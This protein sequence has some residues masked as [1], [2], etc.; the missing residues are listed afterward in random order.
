MCVFVLYIFLS[1]YLSRFG[2]RRADFYPHNMME[3]NVHPLFLSLREAL[4]QVISGSVGVH[5]GVD[6]SEQ[7]TYVQVGLLI[8]SY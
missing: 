7:G 8:C 6:A 1:F 3:E 4:Q 5:V 2:S